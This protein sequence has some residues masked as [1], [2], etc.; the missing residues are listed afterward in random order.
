MYAPRNREY[1]TPLNQRVAEAK[2]RASEKGRA[3]Q[4]RGEAARKVYAASPHGKRVKKNN[5]LQRLYGIN[6]VEFERRVAEQNGVCLTCP[7][8]ATEVDHDHTTGRIRGILC[9]RCNVALG[10]MRHGQ[11]LRG[12]KPLGQSVR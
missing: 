2:Y 3:N 11:S 10:M 12:R 6:L 9:I 1:K 5:A 8:A 7:D 4:Q